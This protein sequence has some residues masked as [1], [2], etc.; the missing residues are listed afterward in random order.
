M[1]DVRESTLW[2]V[3]YY[4]GTT[5]DI[6]ALD[7]SLSGKSPEYK[8]CGDFYELL[9]LVLRMCVAKKKTRQSDKIVLINCVS[10]SCV[11]FGLKYLS[12]QASKLQYQSGYI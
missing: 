4:C 11:F 6:L 12:V 10:L 3:L 9:A 5:F 1:A 2:Y 8:P 7:L